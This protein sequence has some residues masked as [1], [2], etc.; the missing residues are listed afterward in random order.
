MRLLGEATHDRSLVLWTQLAGHHRID[1]SS[2][3]STD[4][5]FG[6]AGSY[7]T[8]WACFLLWEEKGILPTAWGCTKCELLSIWPNT[9]EIWQCQPPST[10]NTH[11][12]VSVR[13]FWLHLLNRIQT[14][15]TRLKL[16]S[17]SSS[18]STCPYVRRRYK[19]WVRQNVH[20]GFSIRRLQ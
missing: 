3:A 2:S 20:V 5:S 6:A 14:N 1:P 12:H 13:S 17:L 10:W 4:L 16:C 11:F 18:H 19:Y 8:F 15:S 7:L 9:S